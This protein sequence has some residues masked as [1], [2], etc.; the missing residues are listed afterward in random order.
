MH[1]KFLRC[2]QSNC[3]TQ[4]SLALAQKAFRTTATV[5]LD[6]HRFEAIANALCEGIDAVNAATLRN[7][8]QSF[9]PLKTILDTASKTSDLSELESAAKTMQG[10][11]DQ[12]KQLA[13]AASVMGLGEMGYYNILQYAVKKGAIDTNI[14][15]E[16]LLNRFQNIEMQIDHNQLGSLMLKAA[17]IAQD[18]LEKDKTA[19][20]HFVIDA[21]LLVNKNSDQMVKILDDLQSIDASLLAYLNIFESLDEAINLKNRTNLIATI[22][23]LYGKSSESGRQLQ[24]LVN[25]I[26][27]PLFSE[28]AKNVATDITK[29][30]TLKPQALA[31]QNISRQ[32]VFRAMM[33]RFNLIMP[34]IFKNYRE[35]F[36]SGK[37]N[38]DILHLIS[39]NVN[40]MIADLMQKTYSNEGS[41]RHGASAHKTII[42]QAQAEAER[43]ADQFMNQSGAPVSPNAMTA[44]KD[45]LAEAFQ[46]ALQVPDVQTVISALPFIGKM[47][48]TEMQQFKNT[49]PGALNSFSN[50][51]NT[52]LNLKFKQQN[53]SGDYQTWIPQLIQGFIT[54]LE[55]DLNSATQNSA[56]AN[57]IKAIIHNDDALSTYIVD[58]FTQDPTYNKFIKNIGLGSAHG[59]ART[60]QDIS[61]VGIV[62]LQAIKQKLEIFNELYKEFHE[63]SIV[64]LQGQQAGQIP[65]QSSQYTLDSLSLTNLIFPSKLNEILTAMFEEANS[66]VDLS[67]GAFNSIAKFY[68]QST[69]GE[70][71]K[72]KLLTNILD[73]SQKMDAMLRNLTEATQVVIAL[74][75]TLDLQSYEDELYRI[76]AEI[77]QAQVVSEAFLPGPLLLDEYN[78]LIKM[79]NVVRKYRAEFQTGKDTLALRKLFAE[80]QSN[81]V[82]SHFLSNQTDNLSASLD[83]FITNSVE[84]LRGQEAHLMAKANTALKQI[85]PRR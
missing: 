81:K 49:I 13:T 84:R 22:T 40:A 44:V 68:Q 59:F 38:A 76:E 47:S 18:T 75:P 74:K 66:I 10:I 72:R 14:M 48:T 28:T 33:G 6:T 56:K 80:V 73:I 32:D 7:I 57:I 35:Y 12:L 9:D 78:I 63:Y 70:D 25:T 1:N 54:K 64:S 42:A 43:L 11:L 79:A 41:S 61:N 27:S 24:N 29:Y 45:G 26:I 21:F 8:Q 46:N 5:G 60:Q 17:Y 3:A 30:E 19:V 23:Y 69:M 2:A 16:N 15:P 37:A 62:A 4:I 51:A 36:T 83:R 50:S 77:E 20:Y 34:T 85:G 82:L 39:V 67:D 65:M 31:V 52:I 71:A 53:I 58:F 55:S